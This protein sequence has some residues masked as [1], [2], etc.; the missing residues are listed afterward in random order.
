[1]AESIDLLVLPEKIRVSFYGALF[2]LAAADATI[3]RDESGLIFEN[4]DLDGLTEAARQTVHGYLI[5]PPDIESCLI[6][7]ND[8]PDEIRF[9][10]MINLVE[11]AEADNYIDEKEKALIDKAKRALRISDDQIAE[12]YNFVK[13]ARRIR[14]RGLD[15]NLAADAMKR[16]ASGLAGVGVPIAAVYLSGSVV[17]FS[18]AGITSG[19]AALG[20]GLGMVS[21]IGVA[22]LVGT[23][24]VIGI[25]KLLDVGGQRKKERMAAERER[26]AQLVIKN[27]QEAINEVINY[28]NELKDAAAESAAN[29][30]AIEVLTRR[31]KALQ[32]ALNARKRAM[33]CA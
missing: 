5:E 18:A 3:D 24:T 28:L 33:E 9:G 32:Q 17:G 26:K 27:L 21:G 22:I 11:V 10:L 23:V 16:A 13:E 8:A 2:A 30:E 31:L 25:S 7:L 15:D 12:I 20:L 4:L 1:M 29:R 14:E 6:S 19:L